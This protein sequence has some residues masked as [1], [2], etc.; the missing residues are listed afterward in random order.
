MK[1]TSLFIILCVIAAMSMAQDGM[2][3]IPSG[4]TLLFDADEHS[5]HLYAQDTS[6]TGYLV[7]PDSV[8]YWE[9]LFEIDALEPY[10]SVPYRHGLPNRK[11]CL[12]RH[13]WVAFSRSA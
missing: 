3:T 11:Q 9:Y 12:P 8:T 1:K 7:L 13:Q 4:Q 10:D 2:V 6:L 5:A